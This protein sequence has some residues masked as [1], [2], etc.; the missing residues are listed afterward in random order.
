[1]DIVQISPQVTPLV[2]KFYKANRARGRA[3][4]QD[5]VW[6]VK[7]TDI[8]AACRMQT[9]SEYFFLSTVYVAEQ[10]R[11]QGVARSLLATV[12]N[13]KI[14]PVYTF[15]YVHLAQFYS[16][17]GFIYCDTLP[18]QLATKFTQYQL[19]KRDIVAMSYLI[20]E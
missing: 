5:Q 1:V 7:K 13:H 16:S 17:V 4:K 19:Q 18:E 8:V 15:S 9:F 2:N 10:Y 14:K 6:V 12:L 3:T 20:S 11:S